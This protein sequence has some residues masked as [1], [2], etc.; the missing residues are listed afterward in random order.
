MDLAITYTNKQHQVIT[1]IVNS[2]PSVSVFWKSIAS[3]IRLAAIPSRITAK[4][5]HNGNASLYLRKEGKSKESLHVDV[6]DN[7][8]DLAPSPFSERYLVNGEKAYVLSPE[9]DENGSVT[10]FTS[11]YGAS[12]AVLSGKGK[13]VKAPYPIAEFW[14]R[15]YEKLAKGYKDRSRLLSLNKE[16]AADNDAGQ[17]LTDALLP[18][19]KRMLPTSTLAK[20]LRDLDKIRLTDT[21]IEKA[22]NA[23]RRLKRAKHFKTFRTNYQLLT[24][25]LP[26]T[27]LADDVTAETMNNKDSLFQEIDQTLSDLERIAACKSTF[28]DRAV[29]IEPATP[30]QI[31]HVKS[32]LTETLAEKLEKVYVVKNKEKETRFANY[33]T[34]Y[35]IN[36]TKEFWHG[37]R[38]ENWLSIIKN[39]LR[40]HPNAII[41]G[42][43][44]GHGIYFA[45]EAKKSFGYTSCY[46]TYWA[47]GN[48]PYG[49]MGLFETAY[50]KPN[51]NANSFRLYNDK[52]I[53]RKLIRNGYG[54]L[55][56]LASKTS[57]Q[58][59]EVVFYHEDAVILRYVVKF[60]S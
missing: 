32:M 40:I 7:T 12:N 41:T 26:K 55:H 1:T 4:S 21:Q 54:C 37:S 31:E 11:V 25:F 53:Q 34:R 60:K 19:T 18:D 30:E 48:S 14:A 13:S 27:V 22:W 6:A 24:S 49:F 47:N 50:G 45:P 15:Y 8:V 29:T 57:L 42:K 35:N 2:F 56:A 17:E 58:H 39:G 28:A 43:M 9:K 51:H 3:F 23:F 52:N 16:N 44:Y 36:E 5:E 20:R 59:D 46:G 38:N 10:S 33:C